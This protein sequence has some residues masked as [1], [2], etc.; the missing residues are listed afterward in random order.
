MQA[1]S[2]PA[3]H[4]EQDIVL[5]SIQQATDR[6]AQLETAIKAQPHRQEQQEEVIQDSVA[7]QQYV[8]QQM[9]DWILICSVSGFS[10]TLRKLSSWLSLRL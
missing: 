10:R 6:I 5:K 9:A 8:S 3:Q 7:M 2:P 4:K 1:Q